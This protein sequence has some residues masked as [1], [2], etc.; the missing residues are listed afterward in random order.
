MNIQSIIS[1]GEEAAVVQAQ[2][3]QNSLRKH[4]GATTVIKVL[5][6]FSTMS[7]DTYYGFLNTS[8]SS[9]SPI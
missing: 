1:K 7:K 6:L 8:N 4:C 2:K 3:G 5:L 9:A